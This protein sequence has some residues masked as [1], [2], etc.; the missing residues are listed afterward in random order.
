MEEEVTLKNFLKKLSM[1]IKFLIVTF[2][3]FF[4][5]PD[6]FSTETKPLPVKELQKS[7]VKEEQ[8]DVSVKSQDHVSLRWVNGS[9][10]EID[11]KAWVAACQNWGKKLLAG[12]GPW[13]W[14]AF[15]EFSCYLGQ[16]RLSGKTKK[17]LWSFNFQWVNDVFMVTVKR[18]KTEVARI[19]VQIK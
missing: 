16:E 10:K 12:E 13:G 11:R 14:G 4:I 3:I 8:E 6:L 15:D 17:S 2:S 18:Y 1:N 19:T 9:E 5:T 7:S